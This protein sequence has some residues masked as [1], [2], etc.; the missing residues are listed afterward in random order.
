MAEPFPA[1]KNWPFPFGRDGAVST[2]VPPIPPGDG[3]DAPSICAA[4]D[5]ILLAAAAETASA[6]AL[7]WVRTAQIIDIIAMAPNQ[8]PLLSMIF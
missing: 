3:T 2:G 4:C 7:A 1:M 6:N 8:P 5:A